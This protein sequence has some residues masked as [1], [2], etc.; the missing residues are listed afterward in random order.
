MVNLIVLAIAGLFL[1]YK[2][3]EFCYNYFLYLSTDYERDDNYVKRQLDILGVRRL[4]FDKIKQ[5]IR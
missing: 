2:A 1:L 4:M 3:G 5:N